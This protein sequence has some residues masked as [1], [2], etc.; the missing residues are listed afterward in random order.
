LVAGGDVP[1]PE[2]VFSAFVNPMEGAPSGLARRVSTP[3][4]VRSSLPW[5]RERGATV[6]NR[7][8][9][10]TPVT[11]SS[12]ARPLR[13]RTG[14]GSHD[15]FDHLLPSLPLKIISLFYL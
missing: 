4:R 7:R 10:L 1:S 3:G 15:C 2:I 13:S 5:A 14:R 11:L 6:S 9:T 12:Y 8:L